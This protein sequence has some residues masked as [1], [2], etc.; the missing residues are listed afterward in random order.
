MGERVEPTEIVEV[1]HLPYGQR[2]VW[3]PDLHRVAVLRH[4]TPAERGAALDE[5]QAEWRRTLRVRIAV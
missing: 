4:L 3:Y 1:D 5:L 2:A